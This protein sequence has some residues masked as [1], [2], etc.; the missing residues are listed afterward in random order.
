[1]K[2]K[3]QIEIIVNEDKCSGCLI[4]QLHHFTHYKFH[5]G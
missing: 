5:E 3:A 4:C 1:M 2:E